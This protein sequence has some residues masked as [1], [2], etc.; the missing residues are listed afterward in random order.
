MSD[1]HNPSS[2]NK[3]SLGKSINNSKNGSPAG[4][5]QAPLSEG[6][7]ACNTEEDQGEERES[8]GSTRIKELL[9]NMDCTTSVNEGK[10]SDSN[11]KSAD[12]KLETEG[13]IMSTANTSSVA[14]TPKPNIR[15]Q[16]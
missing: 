16:Q 6:D 3:D 2:L 4:S 12:S 1:S 10:E 11:S 8:E 5:P 14:E 9:K 13:K 7:A 15:I